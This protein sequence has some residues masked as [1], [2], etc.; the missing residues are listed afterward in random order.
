M[1]GLSGVDS[2]MLY[3]SCRGKDSQRVFGIYNAMGMCG[4]FLAAGVFSGWIQERY[5][6]AAFLTILS[7]GAAAGLSLFLKEVKS[8]D[9]TRTKPEFFRKTV[10]VPLETV[11]FCFS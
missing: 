5:S 11:R 4:L 3:L 2:S 6:F 9:S 10:R 1:T 8:P 7:Y